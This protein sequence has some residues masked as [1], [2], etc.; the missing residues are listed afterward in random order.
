MLAYDTFH[1]LIW[2]WIGIAVVTFVA[3]Q[4][5]VAPYGRHTRSGWGPT[6]SNRLGWLIMESPGLVLMPT[7]FCLGTAEKTAVHWVLLCCYLGH[8]VHRSLIFPWRTRTTGKRMPVAIMGSAIFF[9]LVNTSIMGTWLGWYADYTLA[10]FGSWQFIVG[11]LVFAFGV[12]MNV[13]SD[14]RLLS[15]RKPGETGYK[16]PQGGMFRWWSSPNLVGEVFEWIGY[17]LM[18]WNVAV[19]SFAVWTFANLVPRAA[20]HHKWYKEK[21]ADYPRRWVLW[22]GVW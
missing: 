9:N 18:G 15:L 22:V 20:A 10:W 17:A 19:L 16:I 5:V 8:Y 4:F 1:W 13:D 7:L 12:W 6:V 11:A 14:N 2:A 3:L 21:F